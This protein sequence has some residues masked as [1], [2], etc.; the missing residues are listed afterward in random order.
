MAHSPPYM[1]PLG[2]LWPNSNEA[3]RGQG[4]ISSSPKQEVG[5]PEP[6]FPPKPDQLKMDT[7]ISGSQNY[8]SSVH[9][10]WKSPEA[11]SPAPSKNYPQVQGKTFPSS[12]NSV[13]KDPGLVHIWYNIPLCTIFAQK[14]NGD[15]FRTKLH[16]SKSSTQ[17]IT[18]FEGGLLS[19]S[20]SL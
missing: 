3:K 13:P 2:P 19:Y 14:S 9:G 16:Y 17:S 12:M 1:G 20:V 6:V 5:P 4:G 11:A 18:N 7:S 15:T 8:H 10:S